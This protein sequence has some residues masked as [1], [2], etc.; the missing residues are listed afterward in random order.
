MNI[1]ESNITRAARW[2]AEADALII[3]AGAGMSVDSGLPDFRGS[4][5]I[6]ST[7]LPGNLNERDVLS[8]AQGTCFS[9]APHEAWQFYGRALEICRST[10]PHAG[11]EILL[12]WARSKRHG[13]FVYTSNVDGQFQAAGFSE[14]RIVECHGSILHFQCAGPSVLRSGLRLRPF[15][16][17]RHHAAPGVMAL[18]DRTA[19]CSPIRRGSSIARTPNGCAWRC[20]EPVRPTRW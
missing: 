15:R 10:V 14:E 17:R 11:H 13:A 3:A 20:G 19:C 8:F 9:A 12:D 6:W 2:V 1:A 4:R 16:K 5:G 18:P 7:L